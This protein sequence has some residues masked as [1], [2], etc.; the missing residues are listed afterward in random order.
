MSE[1]EQRYWH[2]HELSIQ[3]L[4]FI[5]NDDAYEKFFD[6]NYEGAWVE[7]TDE[8]ADLTKNLEA[9]NSLFDNKIFNKIRNVYCRPPV[10][11]TQKAYFDSCSE[12]FKLVGPDNINQKA[13]KDFL[14][15]HKACSD[16]DFEYESGKDVSKL[17]LMGL[18]E[19]KI[20]TSKK[21]TKAVR[22]LQK[23]RTEADHKIIESKI[24]KEN[25]VEIF[26]AH[27]MEFNKNLKDI[28][29]KIKNPS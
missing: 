13:L 8:L 22:L 25:L 5:P 24:S 26:F 1:F 2:S 9:V 18:F 17:D 11:N 10:E 6:R 16:K 28:I 19:E 14:K 15:K 23:D 29:E 7:Y 4:E 21:L 20:G 3:E 12:L 27:V